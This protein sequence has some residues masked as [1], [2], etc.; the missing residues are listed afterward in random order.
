MKRHDIEIYGFCPFIE[1]LPLIECR[2]KA[3]LPEFSETVIVCAFPYLIK[4]KGKRNLSYYA[5]VTDYHTVVMNKLK[6]MAKELSQLAGGIFEPFADSSPIREVSTAVKAGIGVLGDNNLLITEKYG[7][8]V[9]IGEIVTDIR[10]QT[11]TIHNNTCLHC[12]MCSK[13]C[14][15]KAVKNGIVN[16]TICLSAITQ[17]KGI[18]SDD[19]IKLIREN[20]IAWGCDICQTV[21]PMNKNAHETYIS[22]FINSAHH[23][24]EKSEI[25]A[26]IKT[27][28]F[29]WRGKKTITR[30]IEILEE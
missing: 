6:S 20:K 10:I 13:R 15:A 5:S 14:P 7:S 3:R 1:A 22:E 21:C 27:S 24:L 23:Y 12:G 4:D 25:S 29:N 17:K 30:N 9:F 19:E 8:F 16:E 11:D 28:A 26:R 18:L 2:A